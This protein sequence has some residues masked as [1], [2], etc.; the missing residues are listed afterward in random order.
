M[1]TLLNRVWKL[2]L[3]MCRPEGHAPSWPKLWDKRTRRSA[4][5]RILNVFRILLATL[6]L[7]AV[8]E[9]G[10]IRVSP[11]TN[12]LP[13]QISIQADPTELPLELR[14]QKEVPAAVLQAIGRGD[15]LRASVR[16]VAGQTDVTAD[17]KVKATDTDFTVTYSGTLESLAVVFELAGVVDTVIAGNE[18]L[19]IGQKDGVVWV[20]T[21]KV[22]TEVFVG[23]GDRGFTWKATGL[24]LDTAKPTMQLERDKAGNV[25]WRCFLVNHPVKLDKPQTMT[26]SLLIQ[27]AQTKPVTA[28]RQTWLQPAADAIAGDTAPLSWHRYL[29]GTHAGR[30][31]QLRGQSKAVLGRA[32]LLD[33]GVDCAGLANLLDGVT[34]VQALEEFGALKEDGQTEFIPY[35]RTAA[36]IRYGEAFSS[37]DVFALAPDDPMAAVHLSVWRRGKQALIAVV[38]ES[39]KPVREQLY[40]LDPAKLFGGPNRLTI[41]QAIAGWDAAKIP[42]DSDWSKSRFPTSVKGE[43][44]VC[45]LDVTDKGYVRA[46]AVKGGTEVYGPL[47]IAPHSYRL[48]LGTGK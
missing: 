47:Y 6:S 29:A 22:L 5:L 36:I 44:P 19:P 38:N 27:P 26:F 3:T 15:Q 39:D 46:A 7:N 10:K 42:A 20:N 24:D 28:R 12:G 40:V 8:A 16:L 17:C 9:P 13:E 34:V 45:L 43:P 11:A 23:S 4:S 2:F 41:S 30:A 1:K 35:W 21:G 18:V 31:T 32:L 37:D 33:A 14:A 25:T 48:L